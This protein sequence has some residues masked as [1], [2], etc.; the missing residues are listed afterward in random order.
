MK[1]LNN[2]NKAMQKDIT[3]HGDIFQ[4]QA[5]GYNCLH[6]IKVGSKSID[7]ENTG[8]SGWFNIQ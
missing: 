3:A 6:N 1:H 5:S 4:I 2:T 7:A 8:T